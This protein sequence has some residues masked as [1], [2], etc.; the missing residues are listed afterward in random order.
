[1]TFVPTLPRADRSLQVLSFHNYTIRGLLCAVVALLLAR[2][3]RYVTLDAGS[4]VEVK[5][6]YEH[7][8][9]DGDELP[10][11]GGPYR[12]SVVKN[13]ILFLR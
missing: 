5:A 11:G 9:V 1:M 4:S 10:P 8:H 3:S 6:D 2:K 12:V 7:V 13:G